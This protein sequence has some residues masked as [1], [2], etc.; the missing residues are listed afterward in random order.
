MTETP[1]PTLTARRRRAR[2]GSGL[3]KRVAEAVGLIGVVGSLLFVGV[4]IRQSATATRAA[5]NAAVADAFRDLSLVQASSPDLARAFAEHA[6]DPA[7]APAEAQVLMLG[8]WRALFH[9]WSD[10]HRQHL[11]GTVDPALYDS[12]VREIV[13]YAPDPAQASAE[14]ES[15]RRLMAWA[16]ASERFL[17][18]TDFQRAVDDLVGPTA[19]PLPSRTTP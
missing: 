12:V 16:W 13:S 7:A 18:S 2:A 3:A 5:T 14:I 9:I 10:V 6:G 15:R 8:F 4:Q 19:E 1:P 11:N 17:F